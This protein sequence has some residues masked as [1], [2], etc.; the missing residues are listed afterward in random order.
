M[1]DLFSGLDCRLRVSSTVAD[2]IMMG[3]VNSAMEAAYKKTCSKE[4]DLERLNEKSRFCELAIMQLEWCLK[5]LQEEMDSYI[6]ESGEEHDALVSDLIET[7]DRIQRRLEETELAITA[8]D[9]ELIVRKERE[10]QLREDLA[11]KDEE[12]SFLRSALQIDQKRIQAGRRCVYR[13]W[14]FSDGGIGSGE[15]GKF[16]GAFDQ[17]VLNLRRTMEDGEAVVKWQSD[18]VSLVEEQEGKTCGAAGSSIGVDSKDSENA[19]GRG[20]SSPKHEHCILIPDTKTQYEQMQI[21]IDGLEETVEAAFGMMDGAFSLSRLAV[22]ELQWEQ[23]I[24]RDT[25][26]VVLQNFLREIQESISSRPPDGKFLVT[27]GLAGIDWLGLMDDMEILHDELNLLVNQ[28]EQHKFKM[29]INI[30][31]AT[32]TTHPSLTDETGMGQPQKERD[33]GEEVSF[34]H[35]N[36]SNE[37]PTCQATHYVAKMVKTHESIIRERTQEANWRKEEILGDSD[38]MPSNKGKETDSARELIQQI[39][40]RLHRVMQN[41]TRLLEVSDHPNL[42]NFEDNVSLQKDSSIHGVEDEKYVIHTSSG[43]PHKLWKVLTCSAGEELCDDLIQL[44]QERE[45]LDMQ[46]SI[47]TEIYAIFFKEFLKSAHFTLVDFVTENI[48]KQ[49]ICNSIIREMVS[50]WNN[51]IEDD[52]IEKI[53]REEISTTVLKG[54]IKDAECC[55]NSSMTRWQEV[56]TQDFCLEG[57]TFANNPLIGCRENDLAEEVEYES[58][59]LDQVELLA[60]KNSE[61]MQQNINFGLS[62]MEIEELN[63][64]DEKEEDNAFHLVHRKLHDT[65]QQIVLSKVQLKELEFSSLHGKSFLHETHDQMTFLEASKTLNEVQTGHLP[66]NQWYLSQSVLMPLE[67]FFQ[68]MMEFDSLVYE[69]LGAYSMR[70]EELSEQLNPLVQYVTSQ[71]KKELLFQKAFMRRCYNLQLAE[72]EVDLLGDEVDALINLLE[73]IYI[74]LDHYSPVLQ[75]YFGI[76][77]LLKLIKKELNRDALCSPRK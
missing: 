27:K 44:Q 16:K 76:M 5:F 58:S 20:C 18:E 70:V 14:D 25:V 65:L 40:F 74:A 3:I 60:P 54:A 24:E 32:P 62:H 21:C 30:Q 36:S 22:A 35:S 72:A 77:D 46:T 41:G 4:G 42:T 47:M 26:G 57:C 11:L 45:I 59:L 1:D 23:N 49:D 19:N 55:I 7:R 8:K 48:I 50:E 43:T 15:L 56:P 67:N 9:R 73:K 31:A 33:F 64:Q 37:D 38:H 68:R 51:G 12:L 53:V 10:L 63:D 2:S 71:K 17:Q 28:I 29:V 66:K 75:H 13:D 6:I 61:L 34:G 39:N 52:N 69:K